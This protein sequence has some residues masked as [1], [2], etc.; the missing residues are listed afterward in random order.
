MV[1]ASAL[2]LVLVS[3]ASA[4]EWPEFRGPGGQGHST[5]R[6]LPLHW[7]EHKNV[8]WKVR[9]PGLGWSTPVVA[10]NRVWLT[11]A[12]EAR[13]VSLRVMAFDIATGKEVVNVE[14]FTIPSYRRG[15][16]PKNSWASPTPVI[17]G[18]RVYVHFGADGTAALTTAGE[19]VWKARF[20]YQ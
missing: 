18:D 13:S 16:N 15:I 19:V 20:D 1:A 17:D 12:I 9:V 3:S 10:G 2:V 5:E 7:D 11:T 14:A 8:A 6:G 4:Q